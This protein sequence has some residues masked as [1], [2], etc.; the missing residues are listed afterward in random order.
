MVLSGENEATEE[1]PDFTNVSISFN[2]NTLDYA[3]QE[4][5]ISEQVSV[6][7]NYIFPLELYKSAFIIHEMASLSLMQE[8]RNALLVS[9]DELNILFYTI[10]PEEDDWKKISKPMQE[11]SSEDI[12]SIFQFNF[13]LQL[14]SCKSDLA[15]NFGLDVDWGKQFKGINLG[16][17]SKAAAE[18]GLQVFKDYVEKNDPNIKLAVYLS[19]LQRLACIDVSPTE[20]SIGLSIA[21]PLLYGPN[22]LNAAYNA[23]GLGYLNKKGSNESPNVEGLEKRDI[24]EELR[25]MRLEELDSTN[26]E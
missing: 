8:V 3:K 25:E 20:N 7:F 26:D 21:N 23:L 13:G 15:W 16:A 12:L 6:L 9:R 24:C 19:K 22:P 14:G 11:N 10:T 17:A 2:N 18:A 1:I 5:K 4:L